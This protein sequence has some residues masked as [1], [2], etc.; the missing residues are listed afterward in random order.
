[1]QS[2]WYSFGNEY[3]PIKEKKTKSI[4]RFL[5]LMCVV[6]YVHSWEPRRY[7]NATDF[8]WHH[9]I[10]CVCRF[11]KSLGSTPQPLCLFV[12]AISGRRVPA[13]QQLF[14]IHRTILDRWASDAFCIANQSDFVRRALGSC[15]VYEW[16]SL[17]DCG[18]CLLVNC[19]SARG[20]RA[21]TAASSER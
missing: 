2:F 15:S 3:K 6:T 1:M 20:F 14:K 13:A 9:K 17:A 12:D 4:S 7:R 16:T 8:R 21:L 10:K 11:V 5:L 18:F 19:P